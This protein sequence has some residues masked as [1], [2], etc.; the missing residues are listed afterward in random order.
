MSIEGLI[1][2]GV[3]L[4][5]SAAYLIWPYWNA[6]RH[7]GLNSEQQRA[8]DTLLTSY[9]RVLAAIR[10]LDEDYQAGKLAAERYQAERA[11]WAERGVTVLQALDA[12]A[13]SPAPVKTKRPAKAAVQTNP[14]DQLDDAVE[15]AIAD[16]VR[17]KAGKG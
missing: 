5:L 10:D 4:A 1:A 2:A 3:I 6:A 16:Y 15:R 8:R 7:P 11:E 14:D 17:V 13:P 9:E 12:Y